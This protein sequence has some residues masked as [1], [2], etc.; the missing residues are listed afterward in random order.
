MRN[1]CGVILSVVFAFL[2]AFSPAQIAVQAA[3]DQAAADAEKALVIARVNDS[4]ITEP[5]VLEAIDDIVRV[6][7]RRIA[8]AQLAQKEQEFFDAGL[9]H[10]ILSSL[11]I[12][13][14]KAEGI[15][16]GATEVDQY[17]ADIRKDFK[18]EEEFNQALASRGMTENALR[19][20][21]TDGILRKNLLETQVKKP[22]APTDEAVQGFYTENPQFF[23]QPEQCRASHILLNVPPESSE[24]QKET[25]KKKLVAI[26][27]DIENKKTTFE[28][29][30]KQHSEDRGSAEQGGD[31]NYFAR[32]RMVKPFEDAAF[33]TPAG[34]MSDIVESRFGYHLIKVV[35]HKKEQK[36]SLEE[37]KEQIKGYL[38]QQE[39]QKAI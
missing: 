30:A 8:P 3:E 20:T 13:T 6:Q 37:A 27:A 2:F 23:V 11:L 29:A 36:V 14:A 5:M 35:E 25:I 28:E 21:L 1:C 17:V 33:G 19:Q 31:L 26:R 12:S 4:E 16:A 34:E 39:H 15:T 7:G 32:G 10:A 24:E 22:D 38:E 9:E 18:T